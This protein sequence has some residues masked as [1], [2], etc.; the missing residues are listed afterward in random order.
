[1]NENSDGRPRFGAAPPRCIAIRNRETWKFCILWDKKT[2]A[3]RE[4]VPIFRR[5]SLQDMVF[6]FRS[7]GTSYHALPT[8]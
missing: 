3:G 6:P 1:M 2:A 5:R 4:Q 7:L 8:S